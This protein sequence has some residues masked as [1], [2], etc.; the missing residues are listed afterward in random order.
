MNSSVT[1]FNVTV[2]A[3][4]PLTP[5]IREIQLQYPHAIDAAP[6][7]H[8]PVQ[9]QLQEGGVDTRAY[10]VV[11]HT[12]D[13]QV[14]IAIKAVENS[15]GGSRYM[16]TLETGMQL[17][18]ANPVSLFQPSWDATEYLLLAG[19]VGI[20]PLISHARALVQKNVSLRLLYA[21][22]SLDEAAYLE[23]LRELLGNRVTVFDASRG[24]RLDIAAQL[25]R[26]HEHAQVY[27]CGP[28]GLMDAVRAEWSRQGRKA[29]NLRYETFGSSG[30]YPAT[31]FT[32]RVP[33]LNREIH[34]QPDQTILDALNAAGVVTLSNCR[35]GECGLCCVDVL[36]HDG[37]LDHRDVFLSPAQRRQGNK[38]CTC[39]SRVAG[40]S[41]TLDPAW[42]GDPDFSRTEI[43]DSDIQ[44]TA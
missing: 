41:V 10:S 40:Q 7:A 31:A 20:T 27:L 29:V 38:L 33:R 1:W 2:H 34:I 32:V 6:G 26:L 17:M 21:V 25:E 35:R 24:E 11:S 36:E 37:V 28:M 44:T 39:V 12:P 13:G 14:T 16:W 18:A 42:R 22:R 5:T 8:V 4:R 15:R 30:G 23:P 9:V 3:V 43:L 19:G